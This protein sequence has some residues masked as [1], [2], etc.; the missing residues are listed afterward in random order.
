MNNF[1]AEFQNLVRTYNEV[2]ENLLKSTPAGDALKPGALA[3]S[4]VRQCDCLGNI[5]RMNGNVDQLSDLWKRIESQLDSKSRDEARA[6][7][8]EAKAEALRLKEV[9]ENHAKT[10]EAERDRLGSEL[11]IMGRRSQHLKSIQPIKNNYPKFIDSH[12]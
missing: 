7:M 4:I 9:C 8:A 2:A 5:E 3:E 10:L 1:I 6:V 12:C 11:G